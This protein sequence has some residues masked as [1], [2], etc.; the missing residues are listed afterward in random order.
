MVSNYPELFK[1]ADDVSRIV[2][3]DQDAKLAGFY[4]QRF[5]RLNYATKYQDDRSVPPSRH[6]IA[7]LCAGV[8]ITDRIILRPYLTLSS[9]ERSEGAWARDRIVIQSGGMGG[10]LPMLNKQ[11]LPERFQEVVD[12]LSK[13]FEVVQL[14]SAQ[15]P[16]LRGVRDLRNKT[17]IRQSAAILHHASLF[18]G[19]VGFLMHLARA[20]ECPSVIVYGGREAPWQ[21]GYNC[22]INLYTAMPCAPCWRWNTCD[23]DRKCMKDITAEEVVAAVLTLRSRP[24]HPLIEESAVI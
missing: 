17:S 18:V 15:D 2:P 5:Q 7:E 12:A 14:G 1:G 24:R 9:E 13:D 11:W 23:F 4:G 21:S 6:I 19:T 8:G 22:N 10:M 3:A 16:P 20:T